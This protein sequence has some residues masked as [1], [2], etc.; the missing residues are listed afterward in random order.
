MLKKDYPTITEW[1]QHPTQAATL[2]PTHLFSS[3]NPNI[4][5]MDGESLLHQLQGFR[6]SENLG[7][8][9]VCRAMQ[10]KLAAT[11]EAYDL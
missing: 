10:T 9:G 4:P 8:P 5:A 11:S 2:I 6:N 7:P 1:G 3:P